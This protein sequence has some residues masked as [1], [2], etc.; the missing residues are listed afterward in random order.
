MVVG[1]CFGL[2]QILERLVVL[3]LPKGD[4]R[5][6]SAAAAEQL[7]LPLGVF[8]LL[9]GPQLIGKRNL[10]RAQHG[11]GVFAGLKTLDLHCDF[12]FDYICCCLTR[13]LQQTPA[14]TT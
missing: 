2:E 12:K 5:L 11:E 7:D 10:C 9:H 14:V 6:V 4:D 13:R 8:R 1:L 3:A